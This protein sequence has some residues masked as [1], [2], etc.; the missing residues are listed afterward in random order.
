MV[1]RWHWWTMER[2]L[3]PSTWTSARPLIWSLTKLERYRFEGWTIPWIR[4]WLDGHSQRVVVNSSMSK[5]RPVTRCVPQR[6]VLE[7]VLSNIFI[8]DID[9]TFSTCVPAQPI[10][11]L[12]P[13]PV[14]S[15]WQ[16]RPT[17]QPSPAPATHPSLSNNHTL[18]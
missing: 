17:E 9:Q 4:N 6:S 8:N 3:L 5:R 1:E 15:W 12:P 14:T 2:Q 13:H 11:C 18:V 10:L 7:P 16:L